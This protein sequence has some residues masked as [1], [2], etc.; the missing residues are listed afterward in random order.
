MNAPAA[1][2][3]GLTP[4]RRA[5]LLTLAIFLMPILIGGGLHLAGWRPDTTANYGELIPPRAL[6]LSALGNDVMTQA[7]GKWLLLIAGGDACAAAC[8]ALIEQTRAIQVSLNRDMG[9]LRRIVLVASPTPELAEL[10]T[11]QPDLLVANPAADWRD[12]PTTGGRPR[13]F[14]V[15]PAGNLMMQYAP[16]ADPKGVRADLERLLKYSWIG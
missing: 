11:R 13:L 5:L 15:D 7:Q 2:R 8:V 6:P 10:R 14:V 9:R 12:G 4:G 1:A 16:G 3:P